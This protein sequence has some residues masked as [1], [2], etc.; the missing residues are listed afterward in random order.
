ML[1]EGYKSRK[2]LQ[3]RT[4]DPRGYCPSREEAHTITGERVAVEV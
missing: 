2:S 3:D 1:R 4:L